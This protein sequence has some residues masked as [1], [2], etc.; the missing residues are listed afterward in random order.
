MGLITEEDVDARSIVVAA[1][2][3]AAV[4]QNDAA[5]TAETA[6]VSGSLFANNGSGVGTATSTAR[7]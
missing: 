7:R 1:V 6:S 3:D 4:A 5:S 2:D